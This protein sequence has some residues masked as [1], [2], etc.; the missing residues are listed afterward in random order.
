[1][2]GYGGGGT[3]QQQMSGVEDAAVSTRQTCKL[4]QICTMDIEF[5]RYREK[6]TEK[7]HLHIINNT[8]CGAAVD[9]LYAVDPVDGVLK[10]SNASLNT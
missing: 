8:D 7:I 10:Y 6:V 9:S 5:V 3:Q 1:M 2:N 4:G